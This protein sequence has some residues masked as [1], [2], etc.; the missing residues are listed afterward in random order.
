MRRLVIMLTL[1]FALMPA[2]AASDGGRPESADG[3]SA[4]NEIASRAIADGVS[5]NSGAASLSASAVPRSTAKIGTQEKIAAD[6]S[7]MSGYALHSTAGCG[8]RNSGGSGIAAAADDNTRISFR[9]ADIDLRLR[10]TAEGVHGFDCDNGAAAAAYGNCARSFTEEGA[11]MSC[12]DGG[13]V[14]AAG[15]ASLRPAADRV[16]VFSDNSGESAAPVGSSGLHFIAGCARKYAGGSDAAGI[17]SGKSDS[18]S[19]AYSGGLK[20]AGVSFAVSGGA[21]LC[22]IPDAKAKKYANADTVTEL[23]VNAGTQ[24]NGGGDARNPMK[25][26]PFA[27]AVGADLRPTPDANAKNC[28]GADTVGAL[29]VN[30]DPRSIAYAGGQRSVDAAELRPTADSRISADCG[31]AGSTADLTVGLNSNPGEDSQASVAETGTVFALSGG[32]AVDPTANS[33]ARESAG[34]VSDSPDDPGIYTADDFDLG[35]VTDSLP[36]EV[37]ENLPTDI[38]DPSTAS[39]TG[40]G[41]FARVVSKLVKAALGP[42]L[43]T[44]SKLLGIIVAASVISSVRSTVKS[45][46]SGVFDFI[47]GLCLMLMLYG[48]VEGMFTLVKNY[49]FTLT[50]V[51]DSFIPVMSAMAAAG[52]DL[53]SAVVSSGGLILGLDLIEKLAANGLM[54]V[55]Q[56]CFGIAMASGVGSLKL[57]GISKLIRD[58]FSW[59]LGLSA[60]AISAVMSFQTTIAARAD[61]L[62]MRAVR[63]AASNAIPVAGGIAADA[64]RTVAGS[65]SLV[66]ST[67]GWAGVVIIALMTLPVMIQ[68][69]LTRIG[70]LLAGT[71]ASVLGLEREKGLLDEVSGLLGSL[72]AV[73]LVASLMFVYALAVFAKGAVALAG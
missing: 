67:V 36:G 65:L 55:L 2:V 38:F 41:F 10:S 7:V 11:R 44:F 52:G 59:T 30:G 64:V 43:K 45:G 60:A 20:P 32:A 14:F 63:F 37:L 47:S 4:S 27:V 16:P 54:P 13:K 70:V 68:V 56:L 5:C 1:A 51:M 31:R 50:G 46:L 3:A 22:S 40:V 21:G 26:V 19:I 33:G 28:A 24:S 29:T 8:T 57:S 35:S 62:S 42:A 9:V 34:D 48:V 17:Q 25:T 66:K 58:G 23:T 12:V 61:S 71:S 49:L 39:E 15:N 6:I 53:N 72:I 73:C 18:R 69:L